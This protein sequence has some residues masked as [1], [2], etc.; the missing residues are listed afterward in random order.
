MTTLCV[1]KNVWFLC[2]L[3]YLVEAD[4]LEI[5]DN[6]EALTAQMLVGASQASPSEQAARY[7]ALQ[8]ATDKLIFTLCGFVPERLEE[9]LEISDLRV[10]GMIYSVFL[11]DQLALS[12]QMKNPVNRNEMLA[13]QRHRVLS[14]IGAYPLSVVDSK[15]ERVFFTQYLASAY[16][17]IASN[18]N[19][20]LSGK[21]GELRSNTRLP[22]LVALS[23]SGNGEA[24]EELKRY[25]ESMQLET[26]FR[27]YVT[28]SPFSIGQEHAPPT[29][30]ESQESE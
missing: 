30:S 27:M 21:L 14:L 9:P 7:R 16:P 8:N 29:I 13:A 11:A 2:V 15:E 12:K 4:E 19:E 26:I 6:V 1:L 23:H 10:V 5:A 18:A 28:N 22:L 17:C 25:S 3:A 20:I 24:A